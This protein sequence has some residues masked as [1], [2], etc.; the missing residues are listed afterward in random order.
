[1]S[2]RDTEIEQA[3]LRAKSKYQA[4]D[5]FKLAQKADKATGFQK[6]PD[7]VVQLAIKEADRICAEHAEELKELRKLWDETRESPT[8][9][10]RSANL[11]AKRKALAFKTRLVEQN[12]PV[13]K[14]FYRDSVEQEPEPEARPAPANLLPIEDERIQELIR[15]GKHARRTGR[16]N[17]R[18]RY[19]IK[20]K[21]IEAEGYRIPDITQEIARE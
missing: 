9:P 17:D 4:R 8:E 12:I 10:N 11:Q 16:E 21:E 15:L 18:T 5:I 14:H 3:V 6:H 1:M 2:V 7:E 20:K 13:P 19:M